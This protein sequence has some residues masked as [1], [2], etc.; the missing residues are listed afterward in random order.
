MTKK[1]IEESLVAYC[2]LGPDIEKVKEYCKD[3]INFLFEAE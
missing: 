2:T 3:V 1:E